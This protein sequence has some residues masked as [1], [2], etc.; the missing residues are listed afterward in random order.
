MSQ[1]TT[2]GSRR[3]CRP[4]RALN[5]T[6]RGAAAF[7]SVLVA[8]VLFMTVANVVARLFGVT[9]RGVIEI[10]ALCLPLIVYL[11]AAQAERDGVHVSV[12]LFI[13]RIPVRLRSSVD[14]LGRV[15]ILPILGWLSG[16]A[17]L[18]ARD[19][20]HSGEYV[21]GIP[22]LPVWSIRAAVALGLLFWALAIMIGLLRRYPGNNHDDTA[23]PI[24]GQG[25]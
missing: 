19:A 23:G 10:S 14:G 22:E 16:A 15:L 12:E 4:I 2:N 11:A 18:R 1:S 8:I 13:G 24:A 25:T 6:L 7:A 9:F 20:F 3:Y 17:A 5:A 21:S